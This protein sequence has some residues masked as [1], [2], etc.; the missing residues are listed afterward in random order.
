M[1]EFSIQHMHSA[2]MASFTILLAIL[3]PFTPLFL[4]V[5][6]NDRV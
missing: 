5:S 2:Q 6:T 4:L 1:S 3:T